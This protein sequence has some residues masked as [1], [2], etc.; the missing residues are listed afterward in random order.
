MF[1]INRWFYLLLS[2]VVMLFLGL[3]YAWSIFS[4]PFSRLYPQWSA[5]GLSATFTVSMVFFCLGGIAAGKLSARLPAFKIL[6]LSAVI[7][8]AG[9][10]LVSF[11]Q[12]MP[13]GI[14]LPYLYASYGVLGG[15]AVGLGYNAIISTINRSFADKTGMATGTIM[16]GFGMG[17]IL[18]GGIT[19][20][21]IERFGLLLVFRCLGVLILAVLLAASLFVPKPGA[22]PEAAP[23]AA[24]KQQGGGA[25]KSMV[26]TA[27]FKLF[28]LWLLLLCSAGLLVIGNAASI[29]ASLGLLPLM[30]LL[31]SVFNGLG[32]IIMGT[33]FDM[34]KARK[35]IVLN[36]LLML[37]A[38]GCF[39]AA[40]YTGNAWLAVLGFVC[41]GIS[42]GGAPAITSPFVYRAFGAENFSLN[43][44]VT[45][46]FL[47]PSAMIG[48][49]VSGMLIESANGAYLSTFYMFLGLAAA[50][51]VPGVLVARKSK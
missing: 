4:I 36:T 43:F 17:A 50:A 19:G 49:L 23:A 21:L 39:L 6:R 41:S 34:L 16:M 13:E 25:V 33:L 2:T 29:S 9:F 15:A 1:K 18:L 35:T 51:V 3:I 14:R 38:A 12:A 44:G 45:N 32:R 10:V 20:S 8:C 7:L 28:Y 27:T 46:T 26:G 24:A 47:I 31:T 42:Y 11:I 30:G 48:P 5:S 40:Y 37:L 22:A